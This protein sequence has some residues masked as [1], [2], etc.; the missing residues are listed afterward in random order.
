[1]L[2]ID[3]RA[4]SYVWTAACVILLLVTI[5]MMRKTLFVFVLAVLLAYLISPLVDIID[6]LLPGRRTRMA[7]LALAYVIFVGL[8]VFGAVQ[9]GGRVIEQANELYKHFPELL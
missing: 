4:A 2:G 3:R 9:I 6:R 8:L 1:M 5:Y 7:A